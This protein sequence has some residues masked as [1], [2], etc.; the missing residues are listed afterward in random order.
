MS[1]ILQGKSNYEETRTANLDW[2]SAENDTEMSAI[3]QEQGKYEK[4]RR[5]LR[6]RLKDGTRRTLELQAKYSML[7]NRKCSILQLPEEIARIIFFYMQEY[8]KEGRLHWIDQWAP[9]PEVVVSH[10]CRQ[11]R[12]ISLA[13]PYLWTRFRFYSGRA[14]RVPFDR[15]EA[16]ME[17][18]K[19]RLLELYL[20]FLGHDSSE[21][22]EIC[23]EDLLKLL[24]LAIGH[25]H[26]W[27]ILLVIS[28]SD[29]PLLSVPEMLEWVSAP[30]LEYMVF[31]TDYS[32]EHTE[33][34]SSLEPT[35]FKDGAPM[36]TSVV[37][38]TCIGQGLLPPLQNITTLCLTGLVIMD[39]P[40]SW[41]TFVGILSLPAL[42]NLS[43]MGEFFEVPAS[44]DSDD[45]I[46]MKNL[47]HFRC[48]RT[49]SI[50]LL[51]ASIV[52]PLLKTLMIKHESLRAVGDGQPEPLGFPSLEWLTLVE[53]PITPLAAQYFARMTKSA[54]RIWIVNKNYDESLFNVFLRSNPECWASLNDV[55][56]EL[57]IG[58]RL[59]E[60]ISF[61]RNHRDSSLVLHVRDE[62]ATQWL[63]TQLSSQLCAYNELEELCRIERINR[64]A[65][66]DHPVWLEHWFSP[67]WNIASEEEYVDP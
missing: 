37:L 12:L 43:I 51:L 32:E 35:I 30:H 4:E 64:T 22:G 55:R 14:T 38:D 29:T 49:N 48:S 17:R 11:W 42:I 56:L 31:C 9:S 27:K 10:V 40:C 34:P 61:A 8:P 47:Q 15:F 5:A 23:T 58:T 63:S 16:Y 44:L 59:N 39:E 33:F 54:N 13:Y 25:A 36:L 20:G 65:V 60:I 3:L 52:A 24:D 2:D 53:T 7:R 62:I 19:S 18:S 46:T 1:K 28:D 50:P 41:P 21:D 67:L 45:L 26:R 6:S 66:V 57:D